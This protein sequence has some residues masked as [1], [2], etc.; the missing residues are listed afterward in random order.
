[1]RLGLS[2]G[3]TLRLLIFPAHLSCSPFRVSDTR[4]ILLCVGVRARVW[5]CL[6][7][8]LGVPVAVEDDDGVGRGEVDAHAASLG[9]DQEDEAV[10]VVMP[11]LLEPADC[12]R[13]C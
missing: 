2:G 9:A 3:S 5:T 7:I 11:A 13:R 8:V 10:R 6:Q 12:N 4:R 1:M